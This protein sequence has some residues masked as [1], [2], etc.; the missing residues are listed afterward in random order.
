LTDK[1]RIAKKD[2]YAD[3]DNGEG[4]KI[5]QLVAREGDEISPALAHLVDDAD[6]TSEMPK[7]RSLLAGR[8][9]SARREA[10]ELDSPDGAEA[11]ADLPVVDHAAGEDAPKG[12]EDVKPDKAA[13]KARKAAKDKAR[14]SAPDK[15]RKAAK[16]K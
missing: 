15:A 12:G 5:R 11:P 7:T 8:G 16:D 10:A 4:Q 6:T 14:K 2:L 1:V 3:V 9:T 13:P